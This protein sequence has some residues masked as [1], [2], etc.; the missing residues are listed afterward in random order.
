MKKKTKIDR[1]ALPMA[2]LGKQNVSAT[3]IFN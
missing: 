2:R 1:I 3:Q